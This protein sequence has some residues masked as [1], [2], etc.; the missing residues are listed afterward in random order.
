MTVQEYKS[1]WKKGVVTYGYDG[2]NLVPLKLNADGELVVNLEAA[3]INIGDVDIAS[4]L[5]DQAKAASISVSPA[6][7][8]PATRQIGKVAIDQSTANANE[9]V[10]KS[11]AIVG[12]LADPAASVSADETDLTLSS[13]ISLAKACKNLDIDVVTHLATLA[14]AVDTTYKGQDRTTTTGGAEELTIPANSK[15]VILSC[16]PS[17]QV[18]IN[19]NADATTSSPLYFEDPFGPII[20]DLGS[21]TKLSAY[22]V[23]GNVGAVFFG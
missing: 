12:T 2:A 6:T 9:V 20:L 7:D 15:K 10:L 19:L 4:P 3:F 16:G 8:I 23:A 11:A 21:V 14:G 1:I 18:Y 5:G 17:T 13:L 22:V